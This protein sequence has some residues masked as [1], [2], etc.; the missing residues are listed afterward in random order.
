M[1]ED[2]L[3]PAG[4]DLVWLTDTATLLAHA[5]TYILLTKTTGWDTT[6]YQ[7]WLETNWH[8]LVASSTTAPPD[9]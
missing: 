7:R 6:A 5:D 9:A 8:R 2:R 1:D 4:S 3:L